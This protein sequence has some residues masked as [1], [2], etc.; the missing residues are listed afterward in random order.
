METPGTEK[1]TI[2]HMKE[3]LPLE[4][5]VEFHDPVETLFFSLTCS[6]S[7][8]AVKEVHGGDVPP[9]ET[10]YMEDPAKDGRREMIKWARAQNPPY[11]CNWRKC[12]RLAKEDGAVAMALRSSLRCYWRRAQSSRLL[13]LTL[14]LKHLYF[15]SMH[16]M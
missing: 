3:D 5:M 13:T 11:P 4:C 15:A 7:R 6:S 16:V 1:F 14:S 12:L 8:A 9:M 10:T 2:N